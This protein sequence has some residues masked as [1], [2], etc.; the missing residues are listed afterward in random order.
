MV[1]N[2]YCSRLSDLRIL[3]STV[4]HGDPYK[5]SRITVMY[6]NGAPLKLGNP[7][8]PVFGTLVQSSWSSLETSTWGEFHK[9]S[10]PEVDANFMAYYDAV[11]P[12]WTNNSLGARRV[13]RLTSS[14]GGYTNHSPLEASLIILSLYISDE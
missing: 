6:G 14:P 10:S 5:Y 13:P 3:C 4:R 2:L 11:L 1:C 7:I 9:P 8:A 12:G